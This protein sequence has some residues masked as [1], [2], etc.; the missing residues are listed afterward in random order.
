MA[1]SHG[2][3]CQAAFGDRNGEHAAGERNTGLLSNGKRAIVIADT[4]I[5]GKDAASQA[6]I[7]SVHFLR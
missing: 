2:A 5:S 7:A 1:G 6:T 3:P 4:A